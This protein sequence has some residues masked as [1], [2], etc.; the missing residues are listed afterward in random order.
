MR[1]YGSAGISTTDQER[2]AGALR[3]SS[4]RRRTISRSLPC[5]LR[6]ILGSVVRAQRSEYG[7]DRNHRLTFLDHGHRSDSLCLDYFP[8]MQPGPLKTILRRTIPQSRSCLT[9]I[10]PLAAD[11][12]YHAPTLCYVFFTGVRIP[13]VAESRR[14]LCCSLA[15]HSP[16]LWRS[17]P[18]AATDFSDKPKGENAEGDPTSVGLQPPRRNGRA[19]GFGIDKSPHQWPG[20]FEQN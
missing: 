19:S 4:P 15:L 8:V 11:F 9:R 1:L 7:P 16:Q 10:P 12:A 3:R 13:V 6:N 5:C 14:F 17:P 18:S 2:S 20:A